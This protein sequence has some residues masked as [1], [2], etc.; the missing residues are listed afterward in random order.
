MKKLISLFVLFLV[1]FAITGCGGGGGGGATDVAA[2]VS[3]T[4]TQTPSVQDF[5]ATE[6]ADKFKQLNTNFTALNSNL[7]ASAKT[8]LGTGQ[9]KISYGPADVVTNFGKSYT[10]TSGDQTFTQKNPAGDLTDTKT[11]VNTLEISTSQLKATYVSNGDNY[12]VTYNGK[13][14]YSGLKSGDTYTITTENLS[15]SAIVNAYH[16]IQWTISGNITVNKTSFPYPA[17]GS[18]ETGSLILDNQQYD[19]TITYDGTTKATMDFSGPETFQMKVD[20]A[21]AAVTELLKSD[22]SKDY[23]QLF[24]AYAV[25]QTALQ[26]NNKSSADR[27]ALFSPN[28]ADDFVNTTDVANKKSELIEITRSRL[29]RYIVNSYSF[30]PK[31]YKKISDT[32]VHVVTDMFINVTRKPGATGA[33]S[34][35]EVPLPGQ[36][37]IW[38]QYGTEWKIYKGIPYTSSE[39]GI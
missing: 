30:T 12:S 38:K 4:I 14:T 18:K 5:I 21:Q 39:V 34:A 6:F 17:A 25:M 3:S 9:Y 33:V 1:A 29:D 11:D 15:V 37:V 2:P 35:A 7:R 27:M 8:S 36:T 22:L 31:S 19:Y 32:E 10:Y 20:L 24:N 16:Q 13:V 26:D 28:I 23:P